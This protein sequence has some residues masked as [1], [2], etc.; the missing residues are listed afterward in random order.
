MDIYKVDASYKAFPPFTKWA[1]AAVDAA[2]WD[3]YSGLKLKFPSASA[4]VLN[5][6]KLVLWSLTTGRIAE[7]YLA[8]KWDPT[9]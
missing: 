8:G 4:T 7:G 2:R 1:Q 6:L 3:R 5:S 9:L